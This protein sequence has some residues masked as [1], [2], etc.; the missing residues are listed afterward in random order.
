M[1]GVRG[2]R[3]WGG[4]RDRLSRWE[5]NVANLTLG[6]E[7]NDTLS[8]ALGLEHHQ[9]IVSTLGD[10]GGRLE[11]ERERERDGYICTSRY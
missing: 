8:Y 9:P 6:T 3:G 7:P 4:D 2:G 1:V 11:I 5:D 10:P